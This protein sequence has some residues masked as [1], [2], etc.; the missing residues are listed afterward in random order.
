MTNE[1]EDLEA[2]NYY[3]TRFRNM[4][5]GVEPLTFEQHTELIRRWPSEY[6]RAWETGDW[7]TI[8]EMKFW[9]AV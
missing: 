9:L 1:A 7:D 6:D 3:A 8:I 4:Y 2:Y 5:P